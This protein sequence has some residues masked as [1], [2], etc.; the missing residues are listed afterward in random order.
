MRASELRAVAMAMFGDGTTNPWVRFLF[1]L[2]DGWESESAGAELP[3]FEALEFL[4]EACAESRRDFSY[5]DGAT[6]ST[7]HSAKGTE[8][9]HVLLLGSWPAW[10]DRAKIEESRR[11][12]YVGM[13]RARKTLTIFDRLDIRPSLPEA[14]TNPDMVLRGHELESKPD[15]GNLLN[16][17]T[18]GLEDIHLG[19]PG[20]FP[21]NSPI[22]AALG[23]L[24]P[25]DMLAMRALEGT[26]LCLFD[27]A[28][29]CVARLAH[30]ADADWA[31]RLGVV[32][33]IQVLAMVFRSADQDAEPTRRERYVVS[34]W[35][36]PVVEITF[37]EKFS[38]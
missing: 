28:G 38:R 14:L 26:G 8:Y 22:H 2:L 23:R 29:V 17:E 27:G 24:I 36:I 32:Q 12:F 31:G 35:E 7:V 13:T 3:L 10:P 34:D 37:A 25:G 21:R 18:L 15:R 5:G 16:Y 4:Y 1:R 9:D 11:A 19:F 20:H 30:K 33:E 6:P